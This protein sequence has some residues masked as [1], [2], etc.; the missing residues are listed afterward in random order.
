M[1]LVR[2]SYTRSQTR[3]IMSDTSFD[4]FL[5]HCVDEY[6]EDVEGEIVEDQDWKVDVMIEK[7]LENYDE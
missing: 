6:Y 1:S 3:W 7:D 4:I 5:D 2:T